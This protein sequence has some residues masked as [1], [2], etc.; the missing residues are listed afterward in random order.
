M[1][2][3]KK[4]KYIFLLNLCVIV[5]GGLFLIVYYKID[6]QIINRPIEFINGV[7]PTNFKLDKKVY[8]SGETP[9]LLTAFCKTRQAKGTVEWSLIDGQKVLYGEREGRN[10]PEGC[11]PQKGEFV[12]APIEPI[13]SYIRDTCDAYF[14]GNGIITISGGRQVYYKYKTE[15]FCVKN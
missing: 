7:D 12:S 5:F 2:D 1:T 3:I 10:I 6:G 13:P 11:Y 4:Y 15:N 8:K 14:V 9:E